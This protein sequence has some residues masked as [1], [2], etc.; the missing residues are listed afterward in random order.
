MTAWTTANELPAASFAAIA[1]G[2]AWRQST[3]KTLTLFLPAAA[4]PIIALVVTNIIATGSWKPFYADYGTDKYR[5]VIDGVPSYW[6]E[7]HGVDRNL[8]SPWMYFIHCT[9]GHHGLFSLTPV[10]ILALAGWLTCFRLR[11]R[12]LKRCWW[13][14]RQRRRLSSRSI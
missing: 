6:M 1:F 8:D 2:L 3:R 10:A 4:V 7:P 11:D 14:A 13:Q 12:A 9:I 5:F